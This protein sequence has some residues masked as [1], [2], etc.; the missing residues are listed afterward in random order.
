MNINQFG[1]NINQCNAL[2]SFAHVLVLPWCRL[3]YQLKS[4]SHCEQQQFT[5]SRYAY[6]TILN[7]A[8]NLH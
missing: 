5:T 8:C 2:D 3:C 7:V 1:T 4:H 6:E